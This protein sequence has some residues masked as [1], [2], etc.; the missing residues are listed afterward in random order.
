MSTTPNRFLAAT[1]SLALTLAWASWGRAQEPEKPKDDG[2]DR[3]LEKLDETKT[4]EA[5]KPAAKK[6]SPDASKGSGD[7][8]PNDKALDNLLEKLGETK[9]TPAPDDKPKGGHGPGDKPPTQPGEKPGPHDLTGKSKDLDQHLEELTGR[10][11]KKKNEEGEGS[12]PLSEIIKEMRDVEKRLGKPDTGDDTR[13]KQAEIVKNLETL[14]EQL[15]QSSGQSGSRKRYLVMKQGRQPGSK[16]G[17]ENP[18]SQAGHAPKM[19]TEKPTTK[20]SL[21]GGKDEWGHLPPELRQELMNVTKEEMLPNRVE[22]IE[23]YFLSLTRKKS[24]AREE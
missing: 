13:K 8:T 2:L 17:S 12:G 9:E 19:K 20:R 5:G 14:I 15:R 10:K 22:L 16:P 11:R 6:A 23:R 1:L 3:L 4:P 18:G 7:V 24:L 21:A